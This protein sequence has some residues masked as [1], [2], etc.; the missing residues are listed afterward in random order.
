EAK[1]LIEGHGARPDQ[2][3]HRTVLRIHGMARRGAADA[4]DLEVRTGEAI[5]LAGLLGSGRTELAR[6]VY[7]AD[8][9]DAGRLEV[10]GR[11]R[12]PWRSTSEAIAHGLGMCPEDRKVEGVVGELSVRENVVLAAQAKRGWWRPMSRRAQQA[13]AA[14]FIGALRI[15]TPSMDEPV[16]RLSGGNQQKVIL[17]RWLAVR[18]RLLIMDEPTRGIDVGAKS[19]IERL[20]G[21]LCGEG[22]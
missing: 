6:L 3:E 22:M 12:R 17:A 7:G 19:E 16:E 21:T 8:R 14:E 1:Q 5:G 11:E 15:K 4:F 18:P 13:M 20:I 9:A 2:A 10:A